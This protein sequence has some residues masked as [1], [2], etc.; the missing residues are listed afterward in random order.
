M[1]KKEDFEVTKEEKD[2]I[3]ED[4]KRRER[5]NREFLQLEKQYATMA[6]GLLQQSMNMQ[7]ILAL[8]KS[9]HQM[10]RE[11]QQEEWKIAKET[12]VKQPEEKSARTLGEQPD[13]PK[14]VQLEEKDARTFGRITRREESPYEW[15]NN[16]K[17]KEPVRLGEQLKEKDARTSGRITRKEESPYEWANGTMR[18]MYACA[19]DQ[20]EDTRTCVSDEQQECSERHE[21]DFIKGKEAGEDEESPCVGRIEESQK[22]RPTQDKSVYGEAAATERPNDGRTAQ[23]L[24]FNDD[25]ENSS[26]GDCY[27]VSSAEHVDGS[28]EYKFKNKFTGKPLGTMQAKISNTTVSGNSIATSSN[29]SGP[30]ITALTG[31]PA[32]GKSMGKVQFWNAA[33]GF[34]FVSNTDGEDVFVHY[35]LLPLSCKRELQIGTSI[36]YQIGKA[37]D[38]REVATNISI[39]ERRMSVVER[40]NAN[41]HRTF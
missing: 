14:A 26:F 19:D 24:H 30:E 36:A 28:I 7:D 18:R 9:G 33:R 13:D 38:G 16:P 35:S 25:D 34:G 11:R 37:K 5:H 29:Q 32:K 39:V 10:L 2:I 20:C 6:P 3:D 31:Q 21:H 8:K 41:G 4:E 1:L 22:V 17:R 15:A 27:E 12:C 40:G 23:K